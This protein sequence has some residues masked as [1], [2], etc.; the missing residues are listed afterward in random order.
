MENKKIFKFNNEVYKLE[1]TKTIKLQYHMYNNSDDL[2]IWDAYKNPSRRKEQAWKYCKNL[3]NDF[4]G[5]NLK[6]VGHNTT[7]FSAG[8]VFDI[9]DEDTGEVNMIYCHITPSYDRFMLIS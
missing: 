4:N 7:I 1:N 3:C 2:T 8:F 5:R 9:E 6:V